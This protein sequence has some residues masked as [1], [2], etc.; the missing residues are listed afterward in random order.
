MS[1]RNESM[2]KRSSILPIN[3][4][5]NLNF[6]KGSLSVCKIIY[7]SLDGKG[8][9][10][11]TGFFIKFKDDDDYNMK[12]QYFLMTCEHVIEK[13]MIDANN[14]SIDIFYHY[15]SIHKKIELNQKKRFMKE[16][17][18]DYNVDITIVEIKKEDDISWVYF[19]EPDYDILNDFDK[20]VKKKIIIH[21]YPLAKEQCYSEGNITNIIK[22]EKRIIYECSTEKG[23]SGSPIIKE[24]S[25]YVFGIHYEGNYEYGY[26]G[27]NNN[28]YF[29]IDVINDEIRKNSVEYYK[30][31][32]KNEKNL[33]DREILA[34][35]T[36]NERIYNIDNFRL[37]LSYNGHR[38]ELNI[39]NIKKEEIYSYVEV[40]DKD[41]IYYLFGYFDTLIYYI[42]IT[43]RNS[44]FTI[45]NKYK[46]NE[47]LL[48]IKKLKQN[49][50]QK[51][52]SYNKKIFNC[53]ILV[54]REKKKLLE[55][56]E[57]VKINSSFQ[58]LNINKNEHYKL[59]PF[60]NKNEISD[61][62]A[63]TTNFL[64][65]SPFEMKE[66]N[67]KGI[68]LNYK[69]FNEEFKKMKLSND[70]G[71]NNAYGTNN[72]LVIL[73]RSNT[74]QSED[75]ISNKIKYKN[76]RT[77]MQY[78]NT[79]KKY[80]VKSSLKPNHCYNSIYNFKENNVTILSKQSLKKKNNFYNMNDSGI[81][82][83]ENINNTINYNSNNSDEY[84]SNEDY[85]KNRNSDIC[86]IY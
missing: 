73:S 14:I 58:S 60:T 79:E 74:Y 54:N 80:V 50:A 43:E 29:I 9:I 10:G 59:K 67:L 22:N 32:D 13:T 82:N 20:C 86:L 78:I 69:I 77:R 39:E 27:N 35:K 7:P 19:L 76:Q 26:H 45:E 56:I 48:T 81:S 85:N 11:G 16:Y 5:K 55:F 24:D 42:E 72:K 4:Y 61:L 34:K 46:D 84:N 44:E 36:W 12:Y 47:V 57:I 23:S 65:N 15:E 17:K 6:I 52:G 49:K 2:N 40:I 25:K 8:Y 18:T 3:C 41:I 68:R 37:S 33:T 64:Y 38:I 30:E 70:I 71:N 66:S 83:N 28:G 75:P 62:P 21:Q 51:H 31:E 1:F 53:E 63:P